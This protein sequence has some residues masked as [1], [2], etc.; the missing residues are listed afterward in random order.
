MCCYRATI[1]GECNRLG[2][3]QCQQHWHLLGSKIAYYRGQRWP[4]NDIF[5]YLKD[6][7]DRDRNRESTSIDSK[8]NAGWQWKGNWATSRRAIA[9]SVKECEVS[10]LPI[11]KWAM[12]PKPKCHTHVPHN[13]LSLGKHPGHHFEIFDKIWNCLGPHHPNTKFFRIGNSLDNYGQPLVECTCII[14][15]FL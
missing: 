9:N 11:A 7:W 15:S 8:V 14:Y 2:W 12:K 1:W 4:S 5:E 13:V 3:G 6:E 10:W